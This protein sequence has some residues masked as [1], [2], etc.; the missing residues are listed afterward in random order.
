ML[1]DYYYSLV[2]RMRKERINKGITQKGLGNKVG[3]AQPMINNIESGKSV[4]SLKQYIRICNALDIPC[5][6]DDAKS[7]DKE[8]LQMKMEIDRNRRDIE[9]LLSLKDIKR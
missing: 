2:K 9:I 4:V 7:R 5:F 3:I 6:E 1:D 8:I